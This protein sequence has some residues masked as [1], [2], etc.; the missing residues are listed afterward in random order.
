LAAQKT[1][2]VVIVAAGTGERVGGGPKQYRLLAGKPVLTRTIEAFTRRPDVSWVQVVVHG[3]HIEHFERL[4]IADPKVLPPVLGALARQGSVLAG[5][6][7][8]VP[9][10]PDLALIQDAARPLV[11]DAV[12]DGARLPTAPRT[13]ESCLPRRHRRALPSTSSSKRTGAQ[14]ASPRSSPTMQQSPNG[15]ACRWR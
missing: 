5:L 13:G 2:A 4:G 10:K 12:I 11:S 7:A 8:L 3:D 9:F 1:I 15:Q 6:E 14:P